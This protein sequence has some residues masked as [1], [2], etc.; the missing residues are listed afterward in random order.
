MAGKKI[1]VEFEVQEDLVKMLEYA[2][3]KYRLGD[4]SKALRCILDYVATDADWKKCSS[5]SAASAAAQMVDGNRKRKKPNKAV[6]FKNIPLPSR[7]E[8]MVSS[9]SPPRGRGVR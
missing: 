9:S 8:G 5:R 2:S 7:G 3:D 1:S 6:R 4:K